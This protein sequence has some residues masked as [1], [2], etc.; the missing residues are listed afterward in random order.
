MLW[1]SITDIRNQTLTFSSQDDVVT[2]P[3]RMDQLFSTMTRLMGEFPTA[4]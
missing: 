4:D 3:F 2:K 1:E